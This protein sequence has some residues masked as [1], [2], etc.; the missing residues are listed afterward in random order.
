VVQTHPGQIVHELSKYEALSSN[1]ST[2]PP[3]HPQNLLNFRG[4]KEK[5]LKQRNIFGWDS[6]RKESYLVLKKNS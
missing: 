5:N 1:P 6:I 2:A 3:S 4:R